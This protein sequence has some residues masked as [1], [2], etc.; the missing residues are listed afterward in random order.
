MRTNATVAM[1]RR[2]GVDVRDAREPATYRDVQGA[3]EGP[4]GAREED[5]C[6]RVTTLTSSS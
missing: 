2:D 3:E 5:A 1:N 6:Q 4:G